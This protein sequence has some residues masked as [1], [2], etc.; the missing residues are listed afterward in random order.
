[1]KNISAYARALVDSYRA[2]SSPRAASVVLDRFVS[3]L[4]AERLQPLVP[5]LLEAVE[6][7]AHTYEKKV[8]GTV[9]VAH[10]HSAKEFEQ[11]GDVIVAEQP[12]LLGGFT[13]R[14]E[15]VAVDASV[16]GAL[17]TLGLLMKKD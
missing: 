12:E 2:A 3:V 16:Q 11:F 10:P 9:R 1:M 4:T 17:T 5:A 7:E 6:R 8:Q 14:R 15:G 13:L